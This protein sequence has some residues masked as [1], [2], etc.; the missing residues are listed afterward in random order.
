MSHLNP[1]ETE[2][3]QRPKEELSRWKGR[4]TQQR[5]LGSWSQHVAKWS[6]ARAPRRSSPD[7]GMET[8]YVDVSLGPG[9]L[10]TMKEA[11]TVLWTTE[12]SYNKDS[13]TRVGCQW[14]Y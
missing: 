6:F 8:E 3:Q 9:M 12:V 7:A 14:W 10:E 1:V 2:G 13:V 4:Q 11:C 5:G